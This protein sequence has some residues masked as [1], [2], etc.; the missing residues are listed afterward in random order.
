[1][2]GARIYSPAVVRKVKAAV[3]RGEPIRTIAARFG[4]SP[5][6]VSNMTRGRIYRP[7][8]EVKREQRARAAVARRLLAE[9][10][11]VSAESWDN[12][13]KRAKASPPVGVVAAAIAERS[14]GKPLVVESLDAKLQ[15]LLP[16]TALTGSKTVQGPDRFAVK[17]GR[18]TLA[19]GASEREAIDRAVS[20]WGGR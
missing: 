2:S 12:A 18:K 11:V 4:M 8:D 5:S 1:M 19:T 20:L 3:A 6:T 13:M 16:G 14:M 9:K 15:R 7:L 17:R 10:R